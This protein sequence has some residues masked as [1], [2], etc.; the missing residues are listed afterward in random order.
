MTQNK[1]CGIVQEKSE[2]AKQ[3]REVD[4]LKITDKAVLSELKKVRS[5]EL[6][7]NLDSFPEEERDGKSDMDIFCDEVYS[8][9]DMY[10]EPGTRQYNNLKWAREIMKKT[11][12]GTV[13]PVD[14][15]FNP[16]YSKCDVDLA[17]EITNEVK[18]LKNC[19]RRLGIA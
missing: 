3:E 10:I 17:S 16:K 5:N 18:R 8:L 13:I 7:E 1:I 6:E 14:M 2:T 15:N 11:K 9:I 4:E 19:T 12:R